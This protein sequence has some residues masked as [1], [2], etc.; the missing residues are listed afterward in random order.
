MA[1]SGER[2]GSPPGRF[3]DGVSVD[4]LFEK[5][6]QRSGRHSDDDLRGFLHDDNPHGSQ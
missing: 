3:L 6:G 5:S 1:P 4:V 2:P